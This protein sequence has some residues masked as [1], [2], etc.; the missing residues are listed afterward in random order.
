M[1]DGEIQI[2]VRYAETDRM[3]LLHHANYLVYFEQARIELLRETGVGVS[4]LSWAGGFT[5]SVGFTFHAAPGAC[6][7]HW[8]AICS[9]GGRAGAACRRWSPPRRF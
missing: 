3:G 6:V 9:R 8:N 2:R 4:S 7:W 5:G 1:P